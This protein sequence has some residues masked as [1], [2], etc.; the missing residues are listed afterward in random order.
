MTTATITD[1]HREIQAL[2]RDFARNEIAPYSAG[3]NHEHH[4]PVGTLRKMGELGLL[5]LVIP[6]EYGGAGLDHTTVCLV[7]EEF[8]AAANFDDVPYPR[9]LERIIRLGLRTAE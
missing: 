7:M 9:L 1:Q 6:E 4:V 2:A 5:G 8:A 3:W